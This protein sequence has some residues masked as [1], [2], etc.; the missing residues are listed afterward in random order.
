MISSKTL[1]QRPT[2]LAERASQR[3][4]TDSIYQKAVFAPGSRSN[5]QGKACQ[6][7]MN[8]LLDENTS[9]CTMH[10]ARS[11]A[12]P[13][14]YPFDAVGYSAKHILELTRR[15]KRERILCQFY[16]SRKG[17]FHAVMSIVGK[18]KAESI[19]SGTRTRYQSATRRGLWGFHR[20]HLHGHTG[21]RNNNTVFP[22]SWVVHSLSAVDLQC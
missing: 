9:A 20:S 21:S 10:V 7:P 15:V 17:T 18:T 6:A 14:T 11:L 4:G 8:L 5:T 22:P 12:F 2:T 1:I 13:R 3:L 19:P 16:L